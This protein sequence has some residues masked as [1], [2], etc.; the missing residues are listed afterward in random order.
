[1]SIDGAR[2]FKNLLRACLVGSTL[3]CRD[4]GFQRPVAPQA[5]FLWLF[6]WRKAA[7]V[8]YCE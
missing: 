1:M 2:A 6:S 5:F 3:L 8:L 7:P 4:R